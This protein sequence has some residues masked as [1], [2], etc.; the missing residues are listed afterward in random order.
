MISQAK[1]YV[2]EVILMRKFIA[3]LFLSGL[4][5]VSGTAYAEGDIDTDRKVVLTNAEDLIF[6]IENGEEVVYDKDNHPYYGAIILPD[7]ANRKTTY[8]YVEGKKHGVAISRFVNGKIELETTY[9]NGKK[10]GDEI[11]F[12][13]NEKPKYKKTYKDDLLD[14]EEFLYYQNGQI[15]KISH[16]KNGKLNGAVTYYNENGEV[17]QTEAYKDGKKNGLARVVEENVIRE[18][19]PYIN[20]K[21]EGTYKT[22]SS[23]GSRREIPYKN[24]KKEGEGKIYSPNNLLLESVVY[25]NDKRNGLYKKYF[26]SGKLASAENYKDDVKN[27]VSRFF[28]SEGKLTSVSYYID[29]VEMAN[30]Q[31]EKRSDLKNIQD[32]IFDKQF[33]KYSNK[34]NLW[35]KILWLALNLDK[36]ETLEILEREM[37]MYAVDIDDIR[38][39]KR[40]SGSQFESE[41]TQLFFGLSPLDYAINVSAPIDTLQKF[42]GQ[43]DEKNSRGLTALRD[44][45]RLNKT[46]MVKFLLLHNADLTETDN[47]GNDILMYAV[48]TN[49]PIEMIEDIIAAGGDVNTQNSLEQTPL[50]VALAQKN[51]E[52]VKLLI[53]SGANVKMSDG[54]DILHYAYDKKVPLDTLK[55]LIDSG[56]DINT[57]DAEGNNLLLK[58]LKNNDEKTALFALENGADINQ[59]D[60]EGETAVSYVLFNKT[61]PQITDKIFA[62][63][64]NVENKL[65]KQNKMVWKV[66][67]EQDK[68]DL[69]KKTWDKMPDVS[70][71]PDAFGEIPVKVALAVQDKPELHKL[72]LSYIEKADSDFVWAA[73]RDKNI[74]L[75]KFLLNKEADVNSTNGDGD[76]LLIYMVKNG[77]DLKFIELIKTKDLDF[78]VRNAD[79]KTALD[80]A[81]EQNHHDLAEYLLK[82]GA[83]LT[84]ANNINLFITNAKPSQ[85]TMVLLLL[86]YMP[87][88]DMT[89]PENKSLLVGAV[90]N[91]NLEFFQYLSE[92]DNPDYTIT[93]ENGNS[94]LLCSADYFAVADANEDKKAMQDNFINIVKTLL[95][96][97]LD[98]NMRNYNG[99]TLLIKLAQNCGSEYDEL[100]KFL[101]DNGAD[102]QA[103]DQYNKTAADY[104]QAE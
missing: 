5:L 93:D 53:K 96:N 73:V 76:T 14:G 82:S 80:I 1:K 35:Y 65:E 25:A 39:Y 19:I 54:Q 67:M 29:G 45:V 34:K 28:D 77:Y 94:L 46:D 62:L 90:K 23:E 70:R 92:Q 33:N 95:K 56:I 64:Y 17:T 99:E 100:A 22:Y 81:I 18:E 57:V 40:W 44:A 69:L 88:I 49:S 98:I 26:T 30:V 71:T 15:K 61:S 104:R 102:V 3:N 97:G 2:S 72:A 10:N 50:A 74:E 16:Y 87:K 89:N 42:V 20:G 4:V 83:K 47:D 31:I 68:F 48:I 85:N 41:N 58:A 63:D 36:P 79:N 55:E 103:K 38:I 66:L 27:G 51:T 37:K 13:F 7:E 86:K 24:D 32:S 78:E 43:Y 75:L 11:L 9:A 6:K 12:F 21:R 60:N 101:I 8:M 52:L 59:K 91:L 84:D